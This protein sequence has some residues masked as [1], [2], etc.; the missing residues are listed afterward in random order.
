MNNLTLFLEDFGL[1]AVSSDH[2]TFS[3][4]TLE[5]ERLESFDKGYRAGWDD[6]IKAKIEDGASLSD[7][8]AQNLQDLSF[9]YHEAHAQILSNLGPL[10]DEILQKMLPSLARDTLGGHIADQLSQLARDTGTVRI[11]IAVAP[12]AGDQVSQLLNEAASNLPISVTE[13]PSVGEG[14]AELRLGSKEISVDLKNVADQIG[15]AVHAVLYDQT[16]DH[17]HA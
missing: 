8:F 15:E 6:A 5:N 4:E 16:E 3:D 1:P 9:T 11:E 10:F 2:P 13:T 7:G 12:G 14:Q 17:A